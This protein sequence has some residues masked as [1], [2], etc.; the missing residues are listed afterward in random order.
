VFPTTNDLHLSW[1]VPYEPGVLRAVGKRRDGTPACE[2]EVWAAGRPVA[3]RL[4]ADRDTIT[5]GLGDVAHI[6]FEIVDSAG[7]VVP[8]ASN[9][10]RFSVSGG[11]ILALDNADLR[12]H[13]S[14]P[15]G[16]KPAYNGRGLAIVRGSIPGM[17]RLTAESDGLRSAAVAVRVVTGTQP[18]LVSPSR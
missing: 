8:T 1:D 2:S 3:I 15:P 14:L 4:R 5:T 16:R 17:L 9:L 7:V 18:A 6:T 10:V 11:N 13:D 12:V